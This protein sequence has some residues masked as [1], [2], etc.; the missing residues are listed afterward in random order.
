[1]NVR[2]RLMQVKRERL[3]QG[4]SLEQMPLNFQRQ[5]REPVTQ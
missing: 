5:N 3:K 4:R 2:M 1:M